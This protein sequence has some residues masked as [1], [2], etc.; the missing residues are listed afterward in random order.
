MRFNGAHFVLLFF[1][2][3]VMNGGNFKQFKTRLRLKDVQ[4]DLFFL[5]LAL[6]S[7]FSR[8]PDGQNADKMKIKQ[9]FESCD[10]N[11]SNEALILNVFSL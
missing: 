11:K 9:E 6:R 7:Y 10:T 5:H 3:F 8:S 1:S 2:R 4:L